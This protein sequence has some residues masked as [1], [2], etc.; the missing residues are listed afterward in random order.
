LTGESATDEVD[1]ELSDFVDIVDPLYVRPMRFENRARDRIDL[2]LKH[3]LGAGT[4]ER[5]IKPA[6]TG[7]QG[8]DFHA[9]SNLS[10]S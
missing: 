10:C 9:A 3:G 7:E 8:R 6:D 2:C 1:V 4:L 5:E